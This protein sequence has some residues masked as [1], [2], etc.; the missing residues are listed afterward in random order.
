MISLALDRYDRHL[1][2]FD[3]TALLPA[4]LQNLK[5]YQVGQHGTLRDGAHPSIDGHVTAS[6]APMP[7]SKA[8]VWRPKYDQVGIGEVSNRLAKREATMM[9]AMLGAMRRRIF[10]ALREMTARRP[11]HMR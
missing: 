7:S 11:G 6:R 3:G 5:V 9:S 2:F 8:R 10:F 1:P 4:A